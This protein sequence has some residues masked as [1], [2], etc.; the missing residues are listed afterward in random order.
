MAF[1]L[2]N[3]EASIVAMLLLLEDQV[4]VP[5]MSFVLPSVNV[6]LA[7]NCWVCPKAMVGFS[8]ATAIDTNLAGIT[9]KIWAGLVIPSLAT[10]ILVVPTAT[11]VANPEASMVAT[12]V[13]LVYRFQINITMIQSFLAFHP[14]YIST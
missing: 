4:A 14:S 11:D 5:V 7:V 2:A 9:V 10:V 12:L 1:G 3:P 13:L 6:P 8:G